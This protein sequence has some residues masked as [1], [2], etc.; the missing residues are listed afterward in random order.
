MNVVITGGAGFI[1]SELVRQCL[2]EKFDVTVI[3]NLCV[4]GAESAKNVPSAAKLIVEDIT[5]GERMHE[6]IAAAKPTVVFHL[7]AHHFIPFCNDHPSE[8]LRVNVEGTQTVLDAAAAAGAKKAIIASSGSIY[9]STDELISESLPAAPVDIYGLSKKMTEDVSNYVASVRGLDC[10]LVRL[11]NTYGPGDP[12]PHLL[13]HIVDSLKQGD[14]I[15]LGNIKTKRDY[16]FV[17]D[18]AKALLDLSK[19]DTKPGLIAN[20]GT[21]DEF[22]AE[23]I[24]LMIGEVLGRP[25]HIDVDQ[26]RV[27]KSDKM[28][29]RAD[30]GVLAEAVD[31][32]PQYSLREG[33]TKLLEAEK[34]L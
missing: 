30:I 12:H 16:V 25:L 5:D 27:R 8:T 10:V 2:Q 31:Y 23:E 7:A 4:G 3:D 33:L 21:G 20:I 24:V 18:V 1:G 15:P 19:A 17:S 34:L 28:H 13:P 29:Q 6:I 11:F 14:T 22:S 9:P 26:S 32:A